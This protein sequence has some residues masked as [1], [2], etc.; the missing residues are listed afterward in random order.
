MANEMAVIE[1][2][3]NGVRIPQWP[4]G[5][6]NATAMCKAYRKRWNNYYQA[7]PTQE[8]IAELGRRLSKQPT[9]LVEIVTSGPNE[10]RGVRVHRIVVVQPEPDALREVATFPQVVRVQARELQGEDDVAHGSRG[11]RIEVATST[12]A[13]AGE[14]DGAGAVGLVAAVACAERLRPYAEG[15]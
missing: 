5:S 1:R 6:L 4:D 15:A 8:Y 2:S 9:E 3:H 14:D 12:L 11:E 7:E 10:L 13:D